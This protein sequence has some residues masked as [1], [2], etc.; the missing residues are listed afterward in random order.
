MNKKSEDLEKAKRL[1]ESPAGQQ[2]LQALQQSNAQ[3]FSRAGTALEN[4]N[5]A[6][7]QKALQQLMQ[8]PAVS[9]LLK[10]LGD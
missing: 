3:A 7:A 9:A 6:D 5:Y 2:L 4:G 10:K 1:A 8:D